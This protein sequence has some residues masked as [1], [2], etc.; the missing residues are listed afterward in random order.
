MVKKPENEKTSIPWPLLV[1]EARLM[2]EW[3]QPDKDL[4]IAAGL[5]WGIV[6]SL[7]A[8]SDKGQAL[9]VQCK[10]E[11]ISLAQRRRTLNQ[12]CK[13]A[14]ATRTGLAKKIR[15]A[16]SMAGNDQKIPSYHRRVTC[17]EIVEDLIF[18]VALYDNLTDILE[19]SGFNQ[20]LCTA[21][22][23]TAQ[24]LQNDNIELKLLNDDYKDLRTLFLCAY[25]SIYKIS[26]DIRKS[27]FEVFPSDSVRRTGYQCQYRKGKK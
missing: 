9:S 19:K 4:L 16:L 18:L 25:H 14:I 24:K 12:Q 21:I 20:D 8:L 23:Q 27:A 10:V 7:P 3:C 6:E 17:S 11:K 15:Y 13:A 26:Q 5:D 2:Y 22:T 1:G